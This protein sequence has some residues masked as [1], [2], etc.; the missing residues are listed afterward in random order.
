MRNIGSGGHMADINKMMKQAKKMQESLIKANDE[1]AEKEVEGSA[2][3]GMVK[4]RT[5]GKHIV[6]SVVI[7]KEVV[8]PNDIETLEDLIVAAVNDSITKANELAAQEFNNITGGL[9]IP[10]LNLF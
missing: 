5:T 1:L 3:G 8:D 9:N 10:G 7:S 4:V 6:K 2:G